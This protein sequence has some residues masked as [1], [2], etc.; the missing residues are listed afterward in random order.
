MVK[1]EK[2]YI[3]TPIFY[4][5]AEPH[6]GTF[7]TTIVADTLA[8]WHRLKDES[9][10][11]V[12][13]TD[14]HGEKAQE[15]A[16]KA[17]MTPKEYADSVAEKFRDTWDR[18]DISYDDFIRTTDERHAKAVVDII[19][20]VDK[21][22]DIYKG[23][24]EGLYCVG[25][26]SFKTEKDLVKGKCPEHPNKEIEHVKEETYFFK[27]SKYQKKLLDFYK[28][29]P[30]FL[31]KK[32]SQE[33]INRVEAGLK[34]LSITRRSV[35]WGIPFPLDKEHVV[36]VWFDALTNYISVLDGPKGDLFK[37]FWPA[38]VHVVGKG[39][40]WFHS[41]IWPAM[42]LSA[43]IELP[44]RVFVHGWW[45]VEGQKISKSL[46]N[47]INPIDIAQKYSTDAL[48]YFLIREMVI[49]EDANYSEKKLI[50][51]I[52]GELVSDLGNLV[53]RVFSLAEKFE[54]EI[55][56]EDE[57][58][59]KL[60]KEAID[61]KMDEMDLAGALE[62]VWE[63]VRETNKYIT[64]K[65]PWKLKGEELSNVLY[66]VLEAT[67]IIAIYISPFL[68][69]TAEKIFR[70]LGIQPEKLEDASFTKFYGNI[71]KGTYLFQKIET[72]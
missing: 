4:V 30:D 55:V 13:G 3:T 31:S 5:N 10:Y 43:G 68:P 54:D 70:Q 60:D 23:D 1:V 35:K 15:A 51:R 66:N 69:Q 65:E 41:V 27:L 67:R 38:D 18:L 14:E 62:K 44:K 24:Y 6:I 42:L 59:G 25:C 58:S 16:D 9:V 57:L 19:K 52:N 12:T 20:K 22:G 46:G 33:I 28:K 64:I 21:N 8:R 26:E 61:K 56:G 29:N 45:L 53:Y 40:D 63:F 2:F 7:Y 32:Y 36:Y 49:G 11:F 71:K 48:R 47:A 39:I 50:E 72:E 17:G 34:D 37:E